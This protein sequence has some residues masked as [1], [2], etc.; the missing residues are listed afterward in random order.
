VADSEDHCETAAEAY[1]DVAPLLRALARRLGKAP[2]ELRI[3]DPYF[4]AGGVAQHLAALGFGNVYNRC[5]LP[6]I[7][8]WKRPRSPRHAPDIGG[9]M[10]A[11]GVITGRCLQERG[12]LRRHSHRRRP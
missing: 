1:R 7:L 8:M 11:G 4:C 2:G 10:Q 9:I 5:G 6:N 3:Y 12:L